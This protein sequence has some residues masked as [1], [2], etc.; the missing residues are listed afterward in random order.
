MKK[1][2]MEKEVRA[3]KVPSGIMSTARVYLIQGGGILGIA[4]GVFLSTVA[5]YKAVGGTA[6][7][8]PPFFDL[9]FDQ[10][11][12]LVFSI[13]GIA[14]LVGGIALCYVGF[15]LQRLNVVS[16]ILGSC[17]LIIP[18]M[19]IGMGYHMAAGI[20]AIC[21]GYPWLATLFLWL[22]GGRSG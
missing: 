10:V 1:E 6:A 21:I 22:K 8:V 20:A 14:T 16:I 18:H 2:E 17:G 5:V 13:V 4:L 3:K 12:G 19:I 9:G 7:M 11:L 15:K